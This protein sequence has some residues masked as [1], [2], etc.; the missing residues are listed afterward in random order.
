MQTVRIKAEGA[1]TDMTFSHTSV[2]LNETIEGLR[3][4]P[5]GV[6]ADGTL[7]GGGHSLEIVK[8]LAPSGHLIGFDRDEAAIRAAGERLGSFQDQVTIVRSNYS[9]MPRILREMGYGS[10]DGIV[11]DLGVSSYQLDTADR[12]FSYMHDAPLDMRMDQRELRTAGDLV[13]E[14]ELNELTRIIRDYGEER[15]AGSIARHIVERRSRKKIETTGELVE[16]IRAS[17]PVKF[18][19]RGGHP[20]KRTFQ[21]LRIELNGELQALED[22]LD[23]MIGM[24]SDGGRLAVITFHSLEDRIVKL[25]FRRNE[26]PCTCPPDFPVCICGK[27][28]AGYVLTRKPILPG[29]RECR[30]N[31][32]AASA[33]LRIFE[34]KV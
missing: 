28:P 5:E 2:L 26:N 8:K 1:G 18:Q 17:I 6:Y 13:N 31:P 22:S 27:K 19:K 20:A 4:R 29:E 9:S 25:A 33:K 10:V 14:S 11:L 21:A 7:G 30:E 32:R 16:I 34:R 3:I 12:G 23:A 24:L 15:F